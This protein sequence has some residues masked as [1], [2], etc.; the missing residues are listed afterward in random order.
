MF[1]KKKVFINLISLISTSNQSKTFDILKQIPTKE[2]LYPNQKKNN[3][4]F[5]PMEVI[6]ISKHYH[7]N[8]MTITTVS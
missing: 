3:Y 4:Y 8:R 2:L 1:N 7:Q 6:S 5:L